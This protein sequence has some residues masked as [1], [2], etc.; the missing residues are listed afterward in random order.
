MVLSVM[1]ILNIYYQKETQQSHS[2]GIYKII[3]KLNKLIGID[4]TRAFEKTAKCY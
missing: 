4:Y 2:L 1:I 3:I